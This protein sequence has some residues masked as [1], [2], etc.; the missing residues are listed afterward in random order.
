[1][2][3]SWFKPKPLHT[4][5]ELELDLVEALEAVTDCVAEHDICADVAQDGRNTLARAKDELG[6]VNDTDRNSPMMAA[7]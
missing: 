3:F 6:I 5:T 7:G 4:P 1:M 2:V